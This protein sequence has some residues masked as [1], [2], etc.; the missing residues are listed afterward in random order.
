MENRNENKTKKRIELNFKILIIIYFNSKILKSGYW[1][2]IKEL[3]K[4]TL[5]SRV[6]KNRKKERKK[7][8]Q[9]H[10]QIESR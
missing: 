6:I 9:I 8:H 4:K 2:N 10:L 7:H 5:L 1:N 3:K